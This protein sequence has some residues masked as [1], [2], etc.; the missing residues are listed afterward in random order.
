MNVR[1]LQLFGQY[2]HETENW[3]FRLLRHLPDAEVHVGAQVFLKCGFYEPS[4]QFY[5]FPLRPGMCPAGE[6]VTVC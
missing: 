2:L 3:C 4:F 1:T 6:S 5:E